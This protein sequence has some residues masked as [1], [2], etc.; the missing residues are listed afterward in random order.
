LLTGPWIAVH[1]YHL[2]T[3]SPYL[4]AFVLIMFLGVLSTFLGQ[5]MA[6]YQDVA[7]RT[8]ITHFIG[9]P[10]NI[11]LTVILVSVGLRLSGYLAA[12]VLSALVVV[13]LLAS[14]S[15]KMTPRLARSVRSFAAEKEVFAFSAT[16]FATTALEFVLAQAD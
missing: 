3:L 2:P 6:G 12:Q 13:C 10:A 5:V 16:A 15:W 4:W 14:A 11:L 1:M 7:R 9:T 8:L